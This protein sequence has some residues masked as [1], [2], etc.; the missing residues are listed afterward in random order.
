MRVLMMIT[1]G[2]GHAFP[3]VPLGWA[4][5]MAGHEVLV[6]SA[7][8]GLM[9]GEAGVRCVDVA[10]GLSLTQMQAKLAQNHPDV[11]ARLNNDSLDPD[12]HQTIGL[13][14]SS[15]LRL[16]PTL[17]ENMIRTAEEWQPDVIVYSPL[18]TP[19]LIAAAKLGIPAVRNEFGMVRTDDSPQLMRHLHSDLF[20]AHGVELPKTLATI[21]IT[22]PSMG[23]IEPGAWQMGVVPFNGGGVFPPGVYDYLVE[24]RRHGTPR[25]AVTFGSGPPPQE[26]ERVVRN[27]MDAAGHMDAQFV[28]AAPTMDLEPFGPLPDNMISVGWAP[29]VSLMECSSLVIHHGGPGS[30]FAAVMSGIPQIIPAFGGLGRPLIMDAVGNRGVGLTAPP[31]ALGRDLLETVLADGKMKAAV[32]EVREEIRGLPTPSDIVARIEDL[33]ET[34]G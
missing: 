19:G 14:V 1:P 17:V 10:P 31:E 34:S 9:L 23:G 24:A 20:E 16:Q 21:D 30:A 28:L 2:A 8:P 33:V 5:Q 4:L 3:M 29:L 25:I 32:H 27:L 12:Y 22:P 13:A 6:A 7:G 18:L 26:T 15:A 11:I